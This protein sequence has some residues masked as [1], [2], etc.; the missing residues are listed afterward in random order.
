[1]YL[2]AKIFSPSCDNA[3][4][5]IFVLDLLG[6]VDGYQL[7]V[8]SKLHKSIH[9]LPVG[10]LRKLFACDTIGKPRNVNDPLIGIQE[11]RLSSRPILGLDD[12]RRQ[13][14]MSGGK[15]GR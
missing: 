9:G 5:F 8:K 6:I 3:F 4:E 1:D 15:A 13:S 10:S 2:A 12:Q 11:L 7:F 14:A